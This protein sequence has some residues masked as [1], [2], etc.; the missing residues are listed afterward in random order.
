MEKEKEK[1]KEKEPIS[2]FR[3]VYDSVME[4]SMYVYFYLFIL[5]S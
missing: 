4:K 5:L 3:Y 2:G 1:V